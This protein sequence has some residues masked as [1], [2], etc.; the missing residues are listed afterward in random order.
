MQK[1]LFCHEIISPSHYM[2]W[3]LSNST[4]TEVMSASFL[5]QWRAL[6]HALPRDSPILSRDYWVRGEIVY[7]GFVY[8]ASA[9]WFVH[10]I[11]APLQI[12]PLFRD[13][14]DTG[15]CKSAHFEPLNHMIIL[16]FSNFY[17]KNKLL[18]IYYGSYF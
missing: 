15:T 14:V 17:P 10:Y 8:M 13:R 5:L 18:Y 6:S 7:F 9:S 1:Q 3:S 4:P 2:R 16:W 12:H 11:I